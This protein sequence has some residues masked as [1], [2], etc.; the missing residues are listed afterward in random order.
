MHEQDRKDAQL[1]ELTPAETVG[2]SGGII[3]HVGDTG[4]MG[5]LYRWFTQKIG[6]PDT[7]SPDPVSPDPVT[8]PY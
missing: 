2:V 6:L 5:D 3:F 4:E 1:T 7:Q 8:Q